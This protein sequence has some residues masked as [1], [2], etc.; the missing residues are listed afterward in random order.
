MAQELVTRSGENLPD[1]GGGDS[2]AVRLNRA[3]ID[4]VVTTARAYPRDLKRAAQDILALVSINQETAAMMLYS[5]PRAGKDISGPGIRFAEALAQ[6]FGNNRTGARVVEVNRA[7]KYVEA[8]GVFHDLQANS[9]T[10]KR[11]RRRISDKN[12][13][14]LSDDMI[15]VTGNAACSIALRNAILAGVPR[16][17]WGPAYDTAV[18]MVAGSPADA[19]KRLEQAI[20]WFKGKGADEAA[21]LA[22]IGLADKTAV[23]PEHIALLQGM[24]SALANGEATLDELLR[25]RDTAAHAVVGNPLDDAPPAEAKSGQQADTAPSGAKAAS[26]KKGGRKEEVL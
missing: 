23:T 6:A 11:V 16:A 12:G 18:Y 24:H 26:A 2:L 21:L 22:A 5:L 9:M 8:E 17:V 1:T 7:E 15:V 13:R 25:Q 3:E 20:A 4:M 10:T 19:G 14:I